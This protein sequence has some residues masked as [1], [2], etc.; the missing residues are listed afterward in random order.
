M[1]NTHHWSLLY[2]L[3]L[4][5]FQSASYSRSFSTLRLELIS[6]LM[7]IVALPTQ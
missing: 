2:A 4:S 6:S 5:Q 7:I 3:G 1:K